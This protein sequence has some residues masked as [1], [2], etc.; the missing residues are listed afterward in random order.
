MFRNYIA[1]SRYTIV[2]FFSIF[3]SFFAAAAY[4]FASNSY[5]VKPG[6]SSEEIM[7]IVQKMK[8]GDTLYFQ[9]GLYKIK[10][11]ISIREKSEITIA[12][13][14]GSEVV[15]DKKDAV[16][17]YISRSDNIVIRGMK[18]RHEEPIHPGEFCTAG[19]LIISYSH[20]ILVENMELNGSGTHGVEIASS[21]SVTVRKSYLHHNSVAA[22]GLY[23]PVDNILIQNIKA[24]NNPKFVDTNI[25]DLE[26]VVTFK[27]NK[28][29]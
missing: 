24:D 12:G 9:P 14:K 7:A 29:K 26:A 5:H 1:R 16:V 21:T 6:A 10:E 27:N 4:G 15:L 8:P 22:L 17:F 11:T 23:N 2:I 28:V 13:Q 20:D 25:F 3:I 18:A 19:V